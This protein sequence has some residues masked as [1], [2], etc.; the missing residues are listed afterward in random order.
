MSKK[1]IVVIGV[2][3]GVVVIGGVGAVAAWKYHEQPQFCATCHIMDPYLESWQASDYGAYAHGAED[4]ACLDCHVPTVQQQVDELVVYMQ[5]DFTVPLEELEVTDEFC[6][7]CHLP[8]DH[9]SYEEVGQ[10]TAGLELNPHSSHLGELECDLCHR[11][12]G[13]SED[14]CADCHGPVATGPGWTTEVTRTAEVQVWAPDMDC[15]ACHVMDPY[16]A[17]LQDTNLLAYAHAQQGLECLDCH[18]VEAVEQ[19][20]EEAV[21]GTPI[22]TGTVEMQF[23]FDCHVANEHTSYEQIIERTKDF[24]DYRIPQKI[25]PH[26]PHVGLESDQDDLGPYECTDCHQMHW[27]SPLVNTC[28]TCHHTNNIESCSTANGCHGINPVVIED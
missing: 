22:I 1:K 14:Y 21:A 10:L 13:L 19:V 28:Y 11:M 4:V 5:G 24:T 2:L 8:N 3:L 17:S 6:Y 15:S 12:H 9:T 20:H 16:F 25:N 27:E 26:D 18:E 23:C 7:D